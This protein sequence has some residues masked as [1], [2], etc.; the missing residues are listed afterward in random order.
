MDLS[1]SLKHVKSLHLYKK[2]STIFRPNI[3]VFAIIYVSVVG[4][5][6]KVF[7]VIDSCVFAL[8]AVV[9]ALNLISFLFVYWSIEW[10][11]LM[12]YSSSD[13]Q[14][15]GFV[16]V[17]PENPQKGKK[18]LVP[19]I[20]DKNDVLFYYQKQ[21][22]VFDFGEHTFIKITS[23]VSLSLCTYLDSEGHQ[24]QSAVEEA[25]RKYGKN[26]FDIPLPSFWELYLEQLLAPFFVFQVFCVALWCL[27]DYVYYSVFIL[28]MLTLFEALTAKT[29]LNNVLVFRGMKILERPVSV[30]RNN[31]WKKILSGD[32]VPG[33][34]CIILG[35]SGQQVIPCDM[36]LLSGGCITNEAM[37]TGESTPQM[38]TSIQS[39]GDDELQCPL[40]LMKHKHHI[41]FGGTSIL[42]H[43]NPEHQDRKNLVKDGCL[44]YVLRT[45]FNTSQGKIVRTILYSSERVTQNNREMF[46]FI[47]MLLFFAL[48]SSFYVLKTGLADPLRKRWKLFLECAMIITSVVPPELPMELS[49]A[50]NT[51]MLS[52]ARESVFCIEPFR[53]LYSGKADYCA[54]DKTG[55]LTCENLTMKGFVQIDEPLLR[56]LSA[57]RKDL[58]AGEQKFTAESNAGSQSLSVQKQPRSRNFKNNKSS[59]KALSKPA[60]QKVSTHSA[61]ATGVLDYVAYTKVA[62]IPLNSLFVIMGCHSLDILNDN[63]IGD[64][65]EIT[66]VKYISCSVH[67]GHMTTLPKRQITVKIHRHFHF[68]SSIKSM[69]TIVSASRGNELKV[70]VKGAAEVVQSYLSSV[71]KNYEYVYK[72]LTFF[73]GRVIA[74]AWKDLPS[75]AMDSIKTMDRKSVESELTFAGFLV[76]DCPLK[77]DSYEAISVLNNSGHQ[78][79]M[80]TGDA[81]LT[82]CEVSRRLHIVN[83]P[84]LILQKNQNEDTMT[85][86]SNDEK[87]SFEFQVDQ[88]SDLAKEFDLCITGSAIRQLFLLP[89]SENFISHIRIFARASPEDK[90]QIIILAKKAGFTTLMCGDGTNDTGALKKAH[91]G[92]AL[93]LNANDPR[94]QNLGRNNLFSKS[95]THTLTGQRS[96]NEKLN[97][98]M[99]KLETDL[100]EST[101][102]Q[103]GDASIAASFTSK[104]ASILPVL[105]IIRQGRCTLVTAMQMFKILA[106]NSLINAYGLSVLYLDG[107]KYGDIQIT[108]SALTTTMCFFSISR[109]KPLKEISSERPVSKIFC[110]YMLCSVLGQSAIHLISLIFVVSQS[111][112]IPKPAPDAA[113]EP[114]L[115]NSSV[116]LISSSQQL[117][118]FL[119][120]Y[121]GYP[122]MQSIYEN[123]TFFYT[124]ICM[125]SII[126]ISATQLIPEFN[127]S[128][129]LVPFTPRFSIMLILMILIEFFCTW[130]LELGC[131]KWL[132]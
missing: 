71:P 31:T 92:I 94:L 77:H 35:N 52:L 132:K 40:S 45:G 100:N 53:I 60:V 103:L 43:S 56:S 93:L 11:T 111:Q 51:A 84:V 69:A 32:L 38:K 34:L 102:V 16:K 27:D 29:R 72:T 59:F 128:F 119:I 63:I 26:V 22:Y 96:K 130:L 67:N 39:L 57:A 2:R 47:C 75:T 89:N 78:T 114:N 44:G 98:V 64:P 24:S 82:A 19:L 76:F 54:F 66:A 21:K 121:Q 5:Y 68:D 23:P 73:G 108:I 122:F 105:S 42:Q 124:I 115:V 83:K 118:T 101:I 104:G 50:I 86:V 90:T 81:A 99:K 95:D 28:C 110:P 20:R 129:E 37:L 15:A 49:L 1:K 123:K 13:I 6:F 88:V 106:L 87:Q 62:D 10:A 109:S 80:I 79:V 117:M 120:N 74:L 91:V 125:A 131:K 9:A 58:E 7:G 8:L 12:N 70:L 36:L 41:V 116:F 126:I 46:F 4:I 25:L 33:D 3:L 55:T 127:T 48:C 107:I 17:V 65:L 14:N 112:T 30:Y 97:K 113:F 85:W 18:E 61:H